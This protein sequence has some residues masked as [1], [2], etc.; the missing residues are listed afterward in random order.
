MRVD[1]LAWI[2][3]RPRFAAAAV[4]AV[5]ALI[6]YGGWRITMRPPELLLNCSVAT[7]RTP[8][9]SGG[10]QV[11]FRP[12]ARVMDGF[13]ISYSESFAAHDG[14]TI[15]WRSD[16]PGLRA[17]FLYDTT[18]R[19]AL[20]HHLANE[21]GRIG[22]WWNRLVPG[23][24]GN[25]IDDAPWTQITD[26]VPAGRYCVTVVETAGSSAPWTVTVAEPR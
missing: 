16:E 17:I 15:E 18:A 4:V 13:T 7:V 25:W 6:G 14:T 8:A 11:V 5:V 12:A 20:D 24:N 2:R 10:D 26:P 3:T 9:T 1:R 23:A 22:L 21:T 19:D